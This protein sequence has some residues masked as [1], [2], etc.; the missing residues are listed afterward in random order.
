MSAPARA[1]A[2]AEAFA[3]GLPF[4]VALRPAAAFVAPAPLAPVPVAPV[5]AAAA[6]FAPVAPVAV[7]AVSAV[8]TAVAPDFTHPPAYKNGP[9]SYNQLGLAYNGFLREKEL[10]LKRIMRPE[11]EA[12]LETMPALDWA[13]AQLQLHG[14][15]TIGQDPVEQL[16]RMARQSGAVRSVLLGEEK[17]TAAGWQARV[18][19]W[20][21]IQS[22]PATAMWQ[23]QNEPEE[24]R[25]FV[26]TWRAEKDPIAFIANVWS[27]WQEAGCPAKGPSH[28]LEGMSAAGVAALQAANVSG[29]YE[30]LAILEIG[31]L[32]L[33][34]GGER[35]ASAVP[36]QPARV[37]RQPGQS[38]EDYWTQQFWKNSVEVRLRN[39]RWDGPVPGL[40]IPPPLPKR[41]KRSKPGPTT[42]QSETK[43]SMEALAQGEHGPKM[44]KQKMAAQVQIGASRQHQAPFPPSQSSLVGPTM[45]FANTGMPF[46]GTS[47]ASAQ[48]AQ[49]FAPMLGVHQPETSQFA[50]AFG[51]VSQGYLSPHQFTGGYLPTPGYPQAQGI[52]PPLAPGYP[53]IQGGPQ[54]GVFGLQGIP[55]Q[56]GN[57]MGGPVFVGGQGVPPVGQ[58]LGVVSGPSQAP[59]THQWAGN[60][61]DQPTMTP[62]QGNPSP[63]GKVGLPGGV[64]AGPAAFVP[65]Q[66]PAPAAP[67]APQLAPPSVFP[68]PVGPAP[69]PA[70]ASARPSVAPLLQATDLAED[71][72][73][74]L[75]PPAVLDDWAVPSPL[76]ASDLAHI[77]GEPA[78][79]AADFPVLDGLDEGLD[80]SVLDKYFDDVDFPSLMEEPA[81]A[82]EPGIESAPAA[83]P[84][85]AAYPA[86][87][88][89]PGAEVYSA[90]EEPAEAE[91]EPAFVTSAL[92]ELGEDDDLIADRE[93]DGVLDD[94]TVANILWEAVR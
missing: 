35:P 17:G 39:P 10:S 11:A 20:A 64:P 28:I 91:A 3:S 77:A 53:F 37:Q 84:V 60:T 9:W 68:W 50:S 61:V 40:Y 81:F 12:R 79:D 73:F 62:A 25:R 57:T 72:S 67:P 83:D 13:F 48:G 42:S 82:P 49:G 21:A 94:G 70:P 52:Y 38:E 71:S 89:E 8:P 43:R 75:C 74:G 2:S 5:S 59:G 51:G 47:M 63:F 90:G 44:K 4:A 58:G 32:V 33:V 31:S 1:P 36:Y 15:A 24:F 14:A 18:T 26:E 29:A 16:R 22:D 23:A 6:P 27:L 69:A 87:A 92:C 54:Y 88:A 85:P 65:A 86:P 19:Q 76:P 30:H 55:P 80:F 7:A 66:N 41:L 34:F 93:L 45:L 78:A 56:G 46:V